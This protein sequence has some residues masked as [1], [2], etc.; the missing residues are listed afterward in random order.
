[1]LQRTHAR[2][3]GSV[4]V[5][6]FRQPCAKFAEGAGDDFPHRALNRCRDFLRQ[7]AD[8]N[9][10]V[11]P[12]LTIV[13]RD[14]ARQ[15]TQQ[16]GFTRAVA[17]EQTDALTGADAQRQVVQQWIATKTVVNREQGNQRNISEK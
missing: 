15:Y 10:G 11:A 3:I 9:I 5:R 12:H 8:P 14:L 17:A 4:S 16:C 6:I 13:W 2:Q 1:M 7:P